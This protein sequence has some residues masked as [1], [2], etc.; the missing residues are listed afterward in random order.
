VSSILSNDIVTILIVVVAFAVLRFIEARMGHKIGEAATDLTDCNRKID[1]LTRELHSKEERVRELEKTVDFLVEAL[2]KAGISAPPPPA[3][4]EETAELDA[5]AK[6]LLLICGPRPDFCTLDR[7]AL[8]R[9]KIPFQRL[10]TA[11]KRSISS[12]LRR[13]R[14]DGTLY[15]W[16]HISCDAGDAGTMLEDGLA[17]A[18]WWNENLDGVS[19]VFLA[20][21]KT[22]TIADSLAGMV[23]VV[24]VLEDIENQ[25]AADFTYAFW[26]RMKEHGSAERAY[27]QAIEEAPR[28]AECTD[29]RTG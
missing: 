15:R 12:E 25:D 19:V 10:V 2:R 16:V 20:A 17:D 14:Q 1:A 6:P 7:Q 18:A 22:A 24:F 9:A 21:C 23:T 5:L 8:K 27:R 13:R 4:K 26:R 11:T 3:K 29:I 28:L